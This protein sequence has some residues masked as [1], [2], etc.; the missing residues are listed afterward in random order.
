MA[1]VDLPL[2]PQANRVTATPI[3][4]ESLV[5]AVAAHDPLAN[6]SRVRLVTLADREFVEYRADSSLRASIDDACHAAGLQRRIACE[7]DTLVDLVELV[8]LGLGVSLLPE[9]AIQMARGR[10]IGLATDPP[11][12][13]DLM[14]VTPHDR[15][16]SPAGAAL[17]ELLVSEP[18]T[19]ELDPGAGRWL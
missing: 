12:P 11:I 3:G 19:T 13:R 18:Q 8:A 5:L 9:A 10:A 2:G 6:R 15:E 4:S 17:L 1:L 16:P 7:V 14:L